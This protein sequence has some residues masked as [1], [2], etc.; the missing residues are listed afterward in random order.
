MEPK[1]RGTLQQQPPPQS[2]VNMRVPEQNQSQHMKLKRHITF[3]V[4]NLIVILIGAL[5]IG[6]AIGA[7]PCLI[8]YGNLNARFIDL[9]QKYDQSTQTNS[10]NTDSESSG[11][12]SD[13]N[14]SAQSNSKNL[15]KLVGDTTTS[16]SLS[17]KLNKIEYPTSIQTTGYDGMP[18]TLTPKQGNKYLA[19]SVEVK[20]DSK[21]PIDLT[22]SLPLQIRAVND[23]DQQY[24]IIEKLYDISGNPQCNAQLQPGMSSPIKYVFEMPSDTKTLGVVWQDISDMNNRGDY[25]TFVFQKGWTL[26]PSDN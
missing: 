16:G 26:E 3:T 18:P 5:V 20:N 17:M 14:S 10:G 22:C 8:A 9:S 4:S 21:Q 1:D 13:N 6:I 11:S 19:V 25:A 23:K 24:S 15:N 2:P 12:A 7:I